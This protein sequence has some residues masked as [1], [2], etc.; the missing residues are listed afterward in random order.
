MERIKDH[1]LAKKR[2]RCTAQFL[3]AARK[4]D[5]LEKLTKLCS[6]PYLD[7]QASIDEHGNTALHLVADLWFTI[8]PLIQRGAFINARNA[9]GQTPL[10]LAVMLGN[11]SCV[12]HFIGARADVNAQDTKGNTPLHKAF[13][14]VAYCETLPYG[15]QRTHLYNDAYYIIKELIKEA[16]ACIDIRNAQGFLPAEH[17]DSLIRKFVYGP[18][19]Q[20]IEEKD[21]A[22]MK[23]RIEQGVVLHVQHIAQAIESDA[24]EIVRFLLDRSND[25]SFEEACYTCKS[26][27]MIHFLI[28]YVSRSLM[29]AQWNRLAVPL[30][31]T[32]FMRELPADVQKKICVYCVFPAIVAEQQ[33]RAKVGLL[34]LLRFPRVLENVGL[35]ALL[36]EERFDVAKLGYYFPTW[37]NQIMPILKARAIKS[38]KIVIHA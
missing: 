25:L 38:Y 34:T 29:R 36:K 22:A 14:R 1:F 27:D 7:V 11:H 37:E 26:V 35:S 19:S 4:R 30:L 21:H 18:F 23:R 10:H 28:T 8:T 6:S 24:I 9:Y 2:A 15:I 32:H 3:E 12:N 17:T 33:R 31:C 5:D 13:N 20:A 16:R